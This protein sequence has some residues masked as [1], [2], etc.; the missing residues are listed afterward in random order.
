MRLFQLAPLM[1]LL[2]LTLMLAA[3]SE[4]ANIEAIEAKLAELRNR[5]QGQIEALPSFPKTVTAKY[6][7][8]QERSPFLPVSTAV[9]KSDFSGPDLNRPISPLEKWDLT[10]LSYRGSMQRGKS[11]RALIITPDQQLISVTKGDRMGRNHGIITHLNAQSL[12][13]LELIPSG[14]EW[15]E[16][17]QII[18]ISK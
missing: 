1:Q 10:Q 16:R 7:Q 15:Q 17:E 14:S 11:I 13:L 18:N 6:T 12:T 8:L 2:P 5:P 9:K 4:Q 3:C